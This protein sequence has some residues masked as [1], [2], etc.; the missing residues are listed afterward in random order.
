MTFT[1]LLNESGK[2]D[3]GAAAV[4][5]AHAG[6]RV[7]PVWGV[8]NGVCDCPNPNCTNGKEAGKHPILKGWPD[9]A[10]DDPDQVAE[11]WRKHPN[12]NIGIATGGDLVALDADIKTDPETGE[13][14]DARKSLQQ[15]LRW[16]GREAVVTAVS[17]TGS[18]GEHW[19]FR[20]PDDIDVGIGQNFQVDGG[21]TFKFLDWRGEG[22]FI[23]APP[24][25]HKSGR[26]YEWRGTFDWSSPAQCPNKVLIE[27]AKQKSYSASA[28]R[29]TGVDTPREV[30]E[31]RRTEILDALQ[32]IS[33]HCSRDEWIK[34]VGMP[35]HDV[36]GG[37]EEGLEIWDEWSSEAGAPLYPGS[38]AVRAQWRSFADCQ[39][40]RGE[41]SL[42]WLARKGGWRGKETEESA[43]VIDMKTGATAVPPVSD[44]VYTDEEIE[45][46][47]ELSESAE[48]PVE[49]IQ[50]LKGPMRAAFDWVT[51]CSD[52][53]HTPEV[54]LTAALAM[55]TPTIGRKFIG[56]T[57][58]NTSIAVACVARSGVGKDRPRACAA[59]FFSAFPGLGF[60]KI[61]ELPNYRTKI[62]ALLL[63][64]QGCLTM[65]VDE[66]GKKMANVLDERKIG[67]TISTTVRSLIGHGQTVFDLYP[68]AASNQERKN[69]APDVWDAGVFAPS[70]SM[71]GFTSPEQFWGALSDSS[72][73]DGFLG[74]H[75]VIACPD[76]ELPDVDGL[77]E[78]DVR[79]VP[80][81][82]QDW[83]LKMQD[84]AVP[85]ISG[86]IV[87][88]QGQRRLDSNGNLIPRDPNVVPWGEGAE[89]LFQRIRQSSRRHAQR[90]LSLDQVAESA[91]MTR[92]PG[93]IATLSLIFALGM[94]DDPNSA[95]IEQEHVRLAHILALFSTAKIAE[96]VSQ[97]DLGG[98]DF[99]TAYR[100]AAAWILKNHTEGKQK[101]NT[102]AQLAKKPQIFEHLWRIWQELD[103]DPRFKI[104]KRGRG[105]RVD[106]NAR[107]SEKS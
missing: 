95:K 80:V 18:G 74:R 106:V 85:E 94:S 40:P 57:N 69:F 101:Y 86:K 50:G 44:D 33:P 26:R 17:R 7:H 87:I 88:G 46:A 64:H 28:N 23:V 65:L 78:G 45:Q 72:V 90:A 82:L 3:L 68:A 107:A 2:P 75:I 102:R 14:I 81:G 43:L 91:V 10:S 11:W 63:A 77:P 39:N 60:G 73:A 71:F 42:F 34:N 19:V 89:E 41:K 53:P 55:V 51:S 104:V 22:G 99:P 100:L 31:E 8:T 20:K 54:S 29:K 83:A 13:E 27:L 49:L 5:Y 47:F 70:L 58:A 25:L 96:K 103:R 62:D 61:S 93:Q 30:S 79:R 98:V 56:P 48:F 38:E 67:D 32:H 21:Q 37:S 36:F 24:S 92:L 6:F 52:S 16:A 66:Y 12:A 105:E 97:G 15:L 84:I 1:Y 9:K 35:L 76:R 4:E 59:N